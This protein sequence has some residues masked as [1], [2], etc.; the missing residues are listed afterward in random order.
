MSGT[1]EPSRSAKPAMPHLTPKLARF[2]ATLRLYFVFRTFAAF[3]AAILLA[4]CIGEPRTYYEAK[5]IVLQRH[6]VARASKKLPP[7]SSAPALTPV[8][9]AP[10]LSVDEKQ[11]L[12]QEFQASQGPKDPIATAPGAAP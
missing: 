5:P 12:F 7:P 9:S 6:A 3:G 10:V 2:G 11:Q 4:G 1:Q 8:L